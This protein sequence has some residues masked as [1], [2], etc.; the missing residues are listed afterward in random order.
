M[1]MCM[2]TY[3][4]FHKSLTSYLSMLVLWKLLKQPS[5]WSIFASLIF[6]QHTARIIN[7]FKS[8]IMSLLHSEYHNVFH[9]SLKVKVF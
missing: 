6:S 7:P 1:Y 2:H 4:P 5:N 9:V 3:T 8:Q